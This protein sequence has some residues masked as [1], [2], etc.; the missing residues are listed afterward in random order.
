[1]SNIEFEREINKRLNSLIYDKI[2]QIEND[3]SKYDKAQHEVLRI[4]EDELLR[5]LGMPEDLL[6]IWTNSH[7]KSIV[8]DKRCSM[9]FETDYQRKSGDASTF[10]VILWF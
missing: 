10:L 8:K 7:V 1:M 2:G 9:M 3:M 4:M 5:L 6:E